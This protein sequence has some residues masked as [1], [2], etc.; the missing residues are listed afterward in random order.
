MEELEKYVKAFEEIGGKV[1]MEEVTPESAEVTGPPPPEMKTHA[2]KMI[3]CPECAFEQPEAEACVK[4]GLSFS[5]TTMVQDGASVPGEQAQTAPYEE[6][7]AE[8]SEESREGFLSA[9]LRRNSS[10]P[11]RSG[12]VFCHP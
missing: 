10:G 1:R 6:A 7:A 2:E 8:T 11:M 4:C 12:K 5:K 9:L 3:A